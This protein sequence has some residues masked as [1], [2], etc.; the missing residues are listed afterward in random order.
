MNVV[1]KEE[2]CGSCKLL[3]GVVEVLRKIIKH[4][5]VLSISESRF[6]HPGWRTLDGDAQFNS[7]CVMLNTV[8]DLMKMVR[9]IIGC[10]PLTPCV[11]DPITLVICCVV[12]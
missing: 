11:T 10:R 1:Y 6:K 3:S 12:P 7:R 5:L 4:L 9:M 2:I 8:K